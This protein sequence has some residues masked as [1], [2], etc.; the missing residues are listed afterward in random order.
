LLATVGVRW[1]PTLSPEVDL[2]L[3]II[4][5]LALTA[6]AAAIAGRRLWWL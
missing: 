4:I 6:I 5:G 2:A 1:H 3:R